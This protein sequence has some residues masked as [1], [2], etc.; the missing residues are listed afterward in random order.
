MPPVQ[1]LQVTDTHLFADEAREIYDTNTAD[2]LRAALRA[3][4][5]G[6]RRPDAVLVTGDVAD[7]ESRGAYLNFRRTLAGVGVPVHCLPGNHDDPA[8]MAELLDRDGF[9][10][11]G[12]TDLGGWRLVLL[13][14]HVDR[15]PS[16]WLRDAELA[17]LDAALREAAGR[18]AL[19][20]VHHPPL[21]LGSAW[22]DGVGL[23]NAAD[24]LAVLDRHPN[25]R[26][27][28][29]GHVHQASERTRG[30]LRVLTTPSTCA[31]F[32]PGTEDCVMDDR[33]PGYR[34][35][36]LASDGT[37]ATD[38]GWATEWRRSAR[39]RDSRAGGMD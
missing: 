20:C 6:G 24:L 37:L 3:A 17:R 35:L 34:W 2:S 9:A 13:D 5:A 25:V 7:D 31:Q 39:P 38:V 33:P 10:F 22:I 14:S 18:P 32:T 12:R 1:L 30:A 21:P 23:R 27:V 16:G 28:V 26:A 29:A 8:L 11:C 36:T 19:V 15:D 4:L